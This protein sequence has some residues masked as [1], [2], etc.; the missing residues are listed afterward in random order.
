MYTFIGGLRDIEDERKCEG[1]KERDKC[2][3]TDSV[4]RT[5]ANLRTVLCEFQ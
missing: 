2:G 1:E 5:C 4:A 3:Q